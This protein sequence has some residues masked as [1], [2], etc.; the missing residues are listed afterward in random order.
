MK[1]KVK[2][3]YILII[4]EKLIFWIVFLGSFGN[5]EL[6]NKAKGLALFPF[7]IMKSEEHVTDWIINHER[8]HFRQQIETLFIGVIL[9]HIFERNYARFVL[10]YSNMDAYTFSSTEQEAYRNQYD[11]TYLQNRKPFAFLK[12]FKIKNKKKVVFG[13]KYGD[14]T[15]CD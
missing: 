2:K 1:L 4:S 14:I 6:A 15:I 13:E 8:I 3:T 9:L 11:E 7:I 10:G 5:R 12:Y